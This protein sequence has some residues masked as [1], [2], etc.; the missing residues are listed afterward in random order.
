MGDPRKIRNKYQTP[1][2]PWQLGRLEQEKP[3]M[4]IYGL[5]TKKELWKV[6][7]KLSGFKD[8]AKKLV[9]RKD[10]QAIKEKQQLFEKL[11]TFNLIAEDSLDQVLG[12]GLEQLL[13]RRLQTLVFKNGLSRSV[14]QARQ[15]I[16]HGHIMVGGKRMTAPGYLVKVA[17]EA[18]ISFSQ[19]S[20]FK[21]EEHPERVVAKTAAEKTEKSEESEKKLVE[22][23]KKTEKK[24]EAPKAEK[25][26]AEES[27]VDDSV[28]KADEKKAENV[29]A[30][31]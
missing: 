16:T 7:S 3:L 27:K 21:D 20:N 5:T 13:D 24:E 2:H 19:K 18:N 11:K 29:E 8:N 4:K 22:R 31:A 10:S 6:N 17:D 26:P 30:K 23:K 25:K 15:M 1:N 9:A 12:L 28:Q 14:K